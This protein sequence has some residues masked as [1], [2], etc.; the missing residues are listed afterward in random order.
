MK[1]IV[2]LGNPGHSYSQTR[3][4]AGFILL[5]LLSSTHRVSFQ[6][7]KKFKGECA[8][9]SH[10]QHDKVIL[11]KP[12][13]FMNL[14]GESVSALCQFYKIAPQDVLVAH[15]ELDLPLGRLRFAQNGNPNGHNGLKSIIQHLGTHDFPR[16]KLG[17]G[18]PIHTHQA[19]SDF[20]LEK[21]NT[22][23]TSLLE[24]MLSLAGE[25]IQTW[26][27][28]NMA[29]TMNRFNQ[30]LFSTPSPTSKSKS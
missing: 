6:L 30:K 14:S 20:V 27:D 16:L 29:T 17:I 3:H 13:T 11:L 28:T 8:F 10:P 22:H 15:D 19:V 5:D 12:H 9:F 24:K 7:E 1:V 25:G 21:F 26:I 4:N 18:R 2:G 23:E